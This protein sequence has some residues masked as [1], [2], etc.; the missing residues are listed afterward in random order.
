MDVPRREYEEKSIANGT[1]GFD[2]RAKAYKPGCPLDSELKKSVCSTPEDN[3]LQNNVKT[4]S[5]GSRVDH[6]NED[7]S[8]ENDDDEVNDLF[9][10]IRKMSNRSSSRSSNNV[11][12]KGSKEKTKSSNPFLEPFHRHSSVDMKGKNKFEWYIT[13]LFMVISLRCILRL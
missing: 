7:S 2:N 12:F 10:Q 6:D 5:P 8:D 11:S 13:V 3:P 9:K 1:A 4:K